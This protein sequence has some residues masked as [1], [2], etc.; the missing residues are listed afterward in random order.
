MLCSWQSEREPREK[1]DMMLGIRRS[2]LAI[3]DRDVGAFTAW[4]SLSL[5]PFSDNLVTALG[6]FY[7]EFV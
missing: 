6:G 5:L 3:I 7:F 1:R 4:D 2:R